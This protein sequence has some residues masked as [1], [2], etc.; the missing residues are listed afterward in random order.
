[1]CMYFDLLRFVF[2]YFPFLCFAFLR[3]PAAVVISLLPVPVL[4][5]NIPTDW[6][7]SVVGNFAKDLFFKMS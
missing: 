2:L 3:R 6:A 7:P 1:M 4:L 5:S